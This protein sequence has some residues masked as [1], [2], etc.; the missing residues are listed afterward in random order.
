[1]N[2]VLY[3][4][5][6][7]DGAGAA[8]AAHLKFGD[9]AKYIPVQYGE[10]VPEIESGSDVFVLDFSY[11][12]DVLLDLKSRMGK[13]VVLD[14]HKTAMEDLIGLDFAKFDMKKSGA[15]LAWEYFHPDT[16][17][18]TLINLIEDQDLWLFTDERTK[19]AGAALRLLDG[20]KDYAQYLHDVSPLMEKGK[21]VLELD[22]LKIKSS[23]DKAT[24]CLY[25]HRS[26][27]ESAYTCALINTGDLISAIG[28]NFY[29]NYEVDFA[30][31]Y[32]VTAD[33]KVVFSFRSNKIDV[34]RLAK[35]LGGGGHPKAAA[36]SVSI[37]VGLKLLSEMYANVV[38]LKALKK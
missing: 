10:P 5:N 2:Y 18:P 28:E 37:D 1:M 14:H 3:H 31:M 9:N 24:A 21:A 12:R 13:L 25:W 33:A 22:A 19:P 32:F 7:T 30:L 34:S 16:D 26:N 15:G 35:G 38:D 17:R 11:K 8:M 27:P 6:C 4:K 29:L 36:A 23:N 20:F